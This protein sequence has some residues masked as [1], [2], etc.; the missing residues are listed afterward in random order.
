MYFLKSSSLHSGLLFKIHLGEMVAIPAV[1]GATWVIITCYDPEQKIYIYEAKKKSLTIVFLVVFQVPKNLIEATV[2][3]CWV[4]FQKPW[5]IY[6]CNKTM[7]Q[8]LLECCKIMLSSD[9]N[10]QRKSWQNNVEHFYI[11]NVSFSRYIF[12]IAPSER[13]ISL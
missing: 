6:W 3:Q 13:K 5:N 10:Y 8:R 9:Y 12:A 1:H 4:D 11:W 2:F 7:F